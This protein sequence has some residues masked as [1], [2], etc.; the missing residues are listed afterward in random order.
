MAQ[1]TIVILDLGS[2]ENER[3]AREIGDFG[4][5]CQIHPYDITLAQ[6]NDIPNVKGV[7]LNGGPNP[8]IHAA[9]PDVATEIYNAPMPVLMVNYKGDDPWPEAEDA[10]KEALFA[11]LLL[12][13]AHMAEV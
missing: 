8:V 5:S 3:L 11:F 9:Q 4:V 6:L 10:R 2:S 1:D 12:C 13:G 7:I